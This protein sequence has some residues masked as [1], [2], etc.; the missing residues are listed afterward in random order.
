M[1][2]LSA[3]ID[4]ASGSAGDVT[5]TGNQHARYLI[6]RPTI[7][8]PNTTA[9]ANLRSSW[10][11]VQQAWDA[12]TTAQRLAWSQHAATYTLTTHS[13]CPHPHVLTGRQDFFRTNVPNHY[14]RGST[15]ANAPTA[16]NTAFAPMRLTYVRGV[17]PQP[18][19]RLFFDVNDEWN[20]LTGSA[21]LVQI[22]A[23]VPDTWNFYERAFLFRR[24]VN[25]GGV[26]PARF[27]YNIPINTN[28]RLFCKVRAITGDGRVS[29]NMH[30]PSTP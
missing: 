8:D 2:A 19:P 18:R 24:V 3:F 30:I 15:I 17:F 26:S 7:T 23:P 28:Q 4:C 6:D 27:T 12:L 16:G 10:G 11:K 5:A 13:F 21:L 22:S 29:K 25:T 9:Q 14:F 1:S 20:N